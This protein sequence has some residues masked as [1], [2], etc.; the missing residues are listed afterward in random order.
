MR[1][2][3]STILDIPAERAFAEVETSRLLEHVAAPLQVFEPVDP[4][5]LPARWAEG[6]FLVRLKMFGLVP[7]GTQW[8]VITVPARGPDRYQVRDNGHG[9]LVS[10]WHHLITIEPLA[11]DRCRYTDEVEVR[12]GVLTPF[13]WAF[14]RLF[15]AHRQRRWRRLVASGFAYRTAGAAA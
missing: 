1:V 15:Y 14:A 6:S 11:A 2:T 13:V 9:T 5:A 3:L 7:I 10:R 12:A 4:P 8:I